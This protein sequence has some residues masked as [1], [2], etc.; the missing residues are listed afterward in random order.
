MSRISTQ[1]ATRGALVR[2]HPATPPPR[3]HSRP[4]GAILVLYHRPTFKGFVDASTVTEHIGSFAQHS[5]FPVWAV[6]T[7]YGPRPG[8]RYLR[9]QA[10]IL[11]YSLF[12]SGVYRLDDDLLEYLSATDAYKVAFFQDEHYYCAQ[13]FAFIDEH[14]ID[15]VFTC[16]TEPEFPKVY[17]ARTQVPRLVTTLP[18]YVSDALLE[19]ARR[20]AKSE[21]DR[22]IDVGYRGRPLAPNMGRGALEKTEIALRFRERAAGSGLTL[23][24]DVEES[25]RLY[26]DAWY[27]FL[28]DCRCVLGVESGVSAFDL[29][30]RIMPEYEHRRRINP[31]LRVDDLQDVLEPWENRI[32]YRTISPRH[33]EAAAFRICQVLYPGSYSG[34]ME[35]GRHYVELRRDF[36]NF[37]GV[38]AAIRDDSFRQKLVD[39]T[40]TDLIASG[41]LSYARFVEQVDR[42]LEEAGASAGP[43]DPG[44]QDLIRMRLKQGRVVRL[45]EAPPFRVADLPHHMYLRTPDP[46][47]RRLRRI[48]DY[49][50]SRGRS[51]SGRA[52]TGGQ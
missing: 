23:D 48:L 27:E 25:G 28:G 3:R 12:G 47:L 20:Y 50:A 43:I 21:A 49:Y 51:T 38:V 16:L 7:A 17:G 24:I 41:E 31:R 42:I 39:N 37:D 10:I 9:F 8:L 35:P 40:Y 14:A 13:R 22:R 2:R 32:Y 18:G 6:N 46:V 15:C 33:F 19:A 34:L 36:S 4:V 26:G 1:Q 29:E 44:E 52:A 5:R 30:D 45:H 11:H